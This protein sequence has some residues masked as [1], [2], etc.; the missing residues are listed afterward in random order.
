[1]DMF[2][3]DRFDRFYEG[4]KI[5][6]FWD[7]NCIFYMNL[8][9]YAIALRCYLASLAGDKRNKVW[10]SLKEISE[11]MNVS[12]NTAKKA[13]EELISAGLLKKE[14]R[15]SKEGDYA[16]TVYTL[17][18][19]PEE[20]FLKHNSL[21]EENKGGGSPGDLPLQKIAGGS[22]DDLPPLRM[23][24][25]GSPGDLRVGHQV[26]EVGHQVITTNNN[27]KDQEDPLSLDVHNVSYKEIN[28]VEG[29]SLRSDPSTRSAALRASGGSE[30]FSVEK[31]N[32]PSPQDSSQE[33]KNCLS[34]FN[35]TITETCRSRR[36]GAVLTKTDEKTGEQ[37][38]PAGEDGREMCAGGAKTE[39]SPHPP[40]P[41]P[42]SSPEVTENSDNNGLTNKDI[43][44]ALGDA[45]LA[46]PGMAER[47]DGPQKKRV[48]ALMGRLYH[49]L[50]CEPV[51]RA[52]DAL[53]K[54]AGAVDDPLRF[55]AGVAEK[56][57]EKLRI[58]DRNA[59]EFHEAIR[60]NGK[61][62]PLTE[63]VRAWLKKWDE[64][65]KNYAEEFFRRQKEEER[66]LQALLE[67]PLPD[68]PLLAGVIESQ[69]QRAREKLS[70]V[71]PGSGKRIGVLV[72]E[73]FAKCEGAGKEN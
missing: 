1:M 42:P 19:P 14:L 50:D 9:P 38:S 33:E 60:E 71:L 21:P 16:N 25:G 66:R 41:P 5:K 27:K 55:V 65:E 17:L 49:R 23:A 31:Q 45:F 62:H 15:R 73:Y 24:G 32:E 57:A 72:A 48:Y 51:Y 20:V 26:T 13:I 58:K 53:K 36:K 68:D 59:A 7:Y 10:P 35:F 63:E 64:D 67:A 4:R 29:S 34:S 6:F 37:P 30:I 69:K 3:N 70:R 28:L 61:M 52:I 2:D 46:V 56:Y 18:D 44:S 47:Y 40:Y 8:S 11:R 43:I 22:P 54:K 12:R 39:I